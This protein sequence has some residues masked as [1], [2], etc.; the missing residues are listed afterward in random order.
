M[1]LRKPIPFLASFLTLTAQAKIDFAHQI[2]PLLRD[3][4]IECHTNGKHK[5]GLSLET[6]D[7]L[8]DS[9][10]V[11][12]GNANES[13]L[14][15]VL[16]AEDPDERM[17]HKADPLPAAQ[18]ALLTQWVNEGLAWEPGFTFREKK[19]QAPLAHRKPDLPAAIAPDENPIDR[20]LRAYFKERRVQPPEPISDAAF[21]R[22]AHLDLI[23]LLPAKDELAVFLTSESANKRSEKIAELLVRKFDYAD[24]WMTFWNDLLRNDYAGTG[25]IDGG[26]KQITGWLYQALTEN[27]PYDQFVRELMN[28]T[29][30]SEGFIK[31][32]KWRG[33]V[34]ASQVPEIQFAQNVSQIFF[35][36]NMKCA[37][38]HD[39]FIDDWK[40]VDAYGMAAIFAG[41]PLEMFRCDKPTGEK[42]DAK[43]LFDSLGSID[44]C[45]LYTSDAADE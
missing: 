18:I 4:C 38:C 28:P 25:F 33:D 31:G 3:N 7:S 22:R 13:I 21:L 30:A 15:E 39:S 1:T 14:I 6:R 19:W 26:R 40:L 45:L 16:T 10:T 11:E 37:S 43:F 12:V 36:E 20:L 35:G 8:L 42:M 23:G 2:L 17:P 32:I 27:K 24:H 41:K 44:P 29:G 5:G 9:E 34:N